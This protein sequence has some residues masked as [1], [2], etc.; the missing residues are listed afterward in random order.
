MNRHPPNLLASTTGRT[1]GHTRKGSVAIVSPN[2]IE[3]EDKVITD[4]TSERRKMQRKGKHEKKAR[5]DQEVEEALK[6]V[7]RNQRLS[8]KES[9]NRLATLLQDDGEVTSPNL[10]IKIKD[11]FSHLP[12]KVPARTKFCSH[13]QP[14]DLAM[15]LR[16]RDRRCPDCQ[17]SARESDLEVDT[18]IEEVF[19]RTRE[20][21]PGVEEMKF[22]LSNGTPR[23]LIW[24]VVRKGVSRF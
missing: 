21:H 17:A 13:F 4:L 5:T 11:T 15:F 6:R 20:K 10:V 9:Q 22:I 14:F 1:N 16:Q 3:I 23:K 2:V 8:R 19:R 18:F 24:N 7:Q 12:I